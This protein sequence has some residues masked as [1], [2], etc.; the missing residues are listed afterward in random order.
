VSGCTLSDG[1]VF[2]LFDGLLKTASS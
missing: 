2:P 1:D